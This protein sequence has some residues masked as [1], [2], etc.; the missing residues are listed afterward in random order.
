MAVLAWI[1][2]GFLLSAVIVVVTTGVVYGIWMPRRMARYWPGAKHLT[3]AQ[4]ETVVRTARSGDRIDD[5]QLAQ[6]VI[7]YS[8]GLHRAAENARPFRWL[9]P[10]GLVVAVGMA[11]WD[12]VYGSW[13][14]AVASGIY[15]VLLLIEV[16][17]WPKR[18][19]RLLSN[20][21]RAADMAE[22]SIR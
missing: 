10:L 1:D 7:D 14:N 12:A 9:L 8:H 17:W 6:A 13:G 3:G 19:D 11:I 20:A 5:P 16:F 21:D 15:L 4:R 18:Q 22:N 2:S